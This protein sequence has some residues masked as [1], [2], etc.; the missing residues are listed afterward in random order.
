MSIVAAVNEP[1]LNVSPNAF[2]LSSTIN[3]NNITRSITSVS[4]ENEVDVGINVTINA[5]EVTGTLSVTS[6][7]SKNQI[8]SA[9][10]DI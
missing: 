10:G 3:T 5:L 4:V 7:I 8:P 1:L 2:V 6:I 9:P